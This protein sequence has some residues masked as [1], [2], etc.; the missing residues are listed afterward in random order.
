MKI[1]GETST[2]GDSALLNILGEPGGYAEAE[3]DG[4][5]SFEILLPRVSGPS[6]YRALLAKKVF[7]H[8]AQRGGET[9]DVVNADVSLGSLHAP[10]IGPV[11]TRAFRE[12]L[13]RPALLF[14]KSANIHTDDTATVH[15][16][17]RD[18]SVRPPWSSSHS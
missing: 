1:V 18:G 8:R 13:L 14:T 17:S 2:R 7:W 10:D 5:R 4:V 16:R 11:E 12:N 9:A 3:M 15:E 6:G